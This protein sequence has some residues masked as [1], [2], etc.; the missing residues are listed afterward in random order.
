MNHIQ[1]TV[2]RAQARALIDG[3][4][5]EIDRMLTELRLNDR[6]RVKA[7]VASRVA[8]QRGLGIYRPVSANHPDA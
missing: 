2:T 4:N 7:I 8:E 1:L 6:P 3:L 5:A